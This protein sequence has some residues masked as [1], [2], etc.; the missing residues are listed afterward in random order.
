MLDLRLISG[1]DASFVIALEQPQLVSFHDDTD[2][3]RSLGIGIAIKEPE[4][5]PLTRVRTV[6]VMQ[7]EVLR[8]M[9][10]RVIEVR[11]RDWSTISDL[12]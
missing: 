7:P 9:S 8:L 12:Q 6:A 10:S 5:Y 4:D 3:R 11:R 1:L 2:V